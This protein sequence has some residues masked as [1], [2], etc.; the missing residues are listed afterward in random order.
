MP[1]IIITPA[2]IAEAT[3]E[4]GHLW[5]KVNATQLARARGT[6]TPKRRRAAFVAVARDAL[7][8]VLCERFGLTRIQQLTAA[9]RAGNPDADFNA[10]N[11][12]AALV[13]FP[14]EFR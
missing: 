13:L 12:A 6:N 10:I 14:S 8:A 9:I 11:A 7:A 5:R 3:R 2:Q 4:E 1:K